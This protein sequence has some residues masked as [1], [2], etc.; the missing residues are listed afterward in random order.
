M[1]IKYKDF[2]NSKLMEEYFKEAIDDMIEKG[3]IIKSDLA[4]L[5]SCLFSFDELLT[6]ILEKQYFLKNDFQKVLDEKIR[7]YKSQIIAKEKIIEKAELEE[8]INYVLINNV[9]SEIYRLKL[10]IEY[11]E[12]NKNYKTITIID[13]GYIKDNDYFN[14]VKLTKE[15]QNILSQSGLTLDIRA[16]LDKVFTVDKTGDTL[17]KTLE[18][19]IKDDSN[20][21]MK[22]N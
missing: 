11:A 18:R 1:E 7:N 14:I 15:V 12:I 2:K 21:N 17:A 8:N 16:R 10:A 5:R 13:S 4:A 3:I 19:M 22:K 9:T 20:H 6:K